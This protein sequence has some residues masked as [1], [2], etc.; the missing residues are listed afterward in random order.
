[1]TGGDDGI[2][3]VAPH[4]ALGASGAEPLPHPRMHGVDRLRGATQSID[5]VRLLEQAQRTE[6]RAGGHLLRALELAPEPQHLFGPHPVRQ[7]DNRR[8]AFESV[9]QQSGG[10]CESVIGLFMRDDLHDGTSAGR[11]C[12]RVFE[13]RHDQDRFATSGHEQAREAFQR[14]RVVTHQIAQVGARSD[15]QRVDARVGRG[16]GRSTQTV[17]LHLVGLQLG[18]ACTLTRRT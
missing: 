16:L 3:D 6:D 10:H 9:A 12:S 4:L 18:H 17:G 5:L 15:Q 8:L 11:L 14:F 2:R 7:P 13:T 1:M